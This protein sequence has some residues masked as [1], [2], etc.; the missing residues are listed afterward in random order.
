MT[1]RR[2]MVDDVLWTVVGY[3]NADGGTYELGLRDLYD[4]PIPDDDVVIAE[5]RAFLN[6]GIRPCPPKINLKIANERIAIR[7]APTAARP[8]WIASRGL[9]PWG[10][11]VWRQGAILPA[12]PDVFEATLRSTGTGSFETER[13]TDQNLSYIDA[14]RAFSAAKLVLSESSF[15]DL[16][17]IDAFGAHTNLGLLF[18]DQAPSLVKLAFYDG[19]REERLRDSLNLTGSILRQFQDAYEFLDKYRD[20]APRGELELSGTPREYP[21]SAL[22]ET[23]VNA[24]L[25]QDYRRATPIVARKYQGRLEIVSPG[26]LPSSLTTADLELGVAAPRNPRVAHV[27]H[28]LDY[29][30]GIGGGTRKIRQAYEGLEAQPRFESTA[31]YTRVVLPVATVAP[32]ASKALPPRRPESSARERLHVPREPLEYAPPQPKRRPSRGSDLRVARGFSTGSHAVS[33][34]APLYVAPGASVDPYYAQERAVLE[35]ARRTPRLR[36]V[37]VVEALKESPSVVA[38]L[39]RR[40]VAANKIVLCGAGDDYWYQLPSA[41]R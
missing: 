37:D 35:L 6:E 5:V 25:H 26:G 38:A 21:E 11:P 22:R 10:V 34:S 24:F 18:S 3:A 4:E 8:F 33:V 9:A 15:H 32:A 12:P 16:G 27:F 7:I 2:E 36:G 39:L 20:G 13:S 19:D 31:N 23:L 28:L 17:F 41:R 1:I 14:K 29:A 30:E 40:M